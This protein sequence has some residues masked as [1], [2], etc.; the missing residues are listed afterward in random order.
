MKDRITF[1]FCVN[2]NG[3]LKIKP[4]LVYSSKT[5]RI[6]KKEN[7]CKPKLSVYWKSNTKAWVTRSTF[8]EWIVE[9]YFIKLIF[10]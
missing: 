5:P 10:K 4:L 8:T 3:G 6:F 1:L 7:V 9:V 2:A